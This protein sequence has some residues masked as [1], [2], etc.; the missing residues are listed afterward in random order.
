MKNFV[1][2]DSLAGFDGRS[3]VTIGTFDGVHLGHRF[4]IAR[5]I[6]AA[7]ARGLESIVLTWDRHPSATLRPDK[8]PPLLTTPERK[9]E[10]LEA[11]GIDNVVV[12]PF[13]KEL[14]SWPPERFVND[15]LVQG[16][17]AAEV[18]VGSNWRFGHKAAGDVAL[19]AGLG[20]EVA[21]TVDGVDLETIGGAAVSSS[22]VRAAIKG[23]DMKLARD[24]MARPFDA[25]GVVEH[26]D[27]RGASLGFPTANVKVDES[28]AHPP[29]GVYAGRARVSLHGSD[30]W[31]P[32]A[33]NLGTNPTFA[34]EGET[35][36][37]RIEAYL[38][39]F[40]GDLYTHPIR[41]EFWERL[42]DEQ[43]FDTPD[44]LIAQ[45]EQDV[46]QTGALIRGE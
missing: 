29:I 27:D 2:L 11:T 18:V 40:E 26:G 31:R 13:D 1:G 15:V 12:L 22:R 42:R 46:I 45:I 5:T 25:D 6:E 21:L 7:R 10:L 44:A 8:V 34:A 24:L 14:S 43:R 35:I 19:L 39:D 37:P 30:V 9:M 28:L 41:I 38:L 3:A 16:L 23:G 20:E 4:L 33:I 36:P 32:A 17:N